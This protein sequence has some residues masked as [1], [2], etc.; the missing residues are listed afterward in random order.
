[1]TSIN[2]HQYSEEIRK[3]AAKFVKDLKLDSQPSQHH[4]TRKPLNGEAGML[5]K[6]CT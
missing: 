6:V 4:F 5:K 3:G 1:M 2:R